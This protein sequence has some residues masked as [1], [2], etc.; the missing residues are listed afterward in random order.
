M[1]NE[2]RRS[3]RKAIGRRAWIDRAD[4]S[5]L[6]QCALGNMSDTGA[7]LVFAEPAQLPDEFVLRLSVDGRVA[8]KCRLAWKDDKYIGV[9]FTAK[10]VTSASPAMQAGEV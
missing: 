4:G 1:N 3:Q 5:P 9:Q 7:K 8:R 2:K 6:M 10:L